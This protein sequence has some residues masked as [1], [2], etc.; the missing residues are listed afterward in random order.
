MKLNLFLKTLSWLTN[1]TADTASIDAKI[2]FFNSWL[3]F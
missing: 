1:P 2:E 3:V